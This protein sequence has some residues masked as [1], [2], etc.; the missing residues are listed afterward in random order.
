MNLKEAFRYQSFLEKMM[1]DACNSIANREHA[2]TVT[3]T[4]NK[5]KA[6]PDAV[7][8]IETVETAA[9]YPNNDVIRFM[10]WLI[11]EREKLTNAIGFAKSDIGF[12]IDAAVETNKF[13]QTANKAVKCMLSYPASKSIEQGRDFKFNAEGNQMPYYYEIEVVKSGAYDKDAAKA[14]MR[15]VIMEADKVSAEIDSAMINADVNYEPRFDVNETFDDVMA[16][17]LKS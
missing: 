16:E 2:I 11:R 15:S 3:K 13:R 17:F 12:N 14:F 4:H 1:S 7:D 6:N 9:F 10:L 5:S 8:F